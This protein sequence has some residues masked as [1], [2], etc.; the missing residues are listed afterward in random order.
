MPRLGPTSRDD[1]I[2]YLRALGFEGPYPGTKHQM[3]IK[4]D[5]V[6]RLPNP[7]RGDIGR[8][9]LTRILRQA[10]ITRDKWESL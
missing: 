9:L 5:L 2:R 8:E 10:G 6:I 3:M 1:L 7:H 4:G